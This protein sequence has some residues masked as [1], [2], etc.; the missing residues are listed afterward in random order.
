MTA[1]YSPESMIL[2]SSSVVSFMRFCRQT[3]IFTS[4]WAF[5]RSQ[6][7]SASLEFRAMGFSQNTLQPISTS[8]L[9]TG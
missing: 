2:F 8:S 1:P 9:V 4:G 3:P 7:S 5:S 6:N